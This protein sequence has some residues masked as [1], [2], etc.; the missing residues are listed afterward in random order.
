M[1]FEIHM[2]LQHLRYDSI[3]SRILAVLYPDRQMA[4]QQL[5][6]NLQANNESVKRKIRLMSKLNPSYIKTHEVNES[7]DRQYS[8]TQYGRWFAICS[9]LKISFL[10]LCIL[11]DIFVLQKTM[12]G[13]DRNGFY[14]VIRIR[15]LIENTTNEHNVYTGRYL[16]I[17]FRELINQNILDR[18]QK[19]I[20]RIHPIVFTLLKNYD[21]D[22]T[23]L[24]R[25]FYS[26]IDCS[27]SRDELTDIQAPFQTEHECPLLISK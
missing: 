7:Y 15:E 26:K 8:L 14:P 9:R 11:S 20:V 23:L 27:V 1:S 6:D 19:N 25:W 5:C 17:K 21:F 2:K 24:Q 16:R 12:N 13:T 3:T 18:L 10:S 4:L 22:L